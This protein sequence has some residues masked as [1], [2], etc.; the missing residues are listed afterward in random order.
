LF[1]SS[2]LARSW[3]KKDAEKKKR[4]SA[5]G[6]GQ[7]SEKMKLFRGGEDR[8]EPPNTHVGSRPGI[9]KNAILWAPLR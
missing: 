6:D 2:N 1:G 3:G 7:G 9:G 4:S 5:L 8:G